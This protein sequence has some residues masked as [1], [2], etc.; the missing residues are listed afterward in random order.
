MSLRN[1]QKNQAYAYLAIISIGKGIA[2]EIAARVVTKQN[3]YERRMISDLIDNTYYPISTQK[4]ILFSCS[5]HNHLFEEK[6]YAI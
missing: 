4:R 5:F 3:T 1:L 6:T 2:Y